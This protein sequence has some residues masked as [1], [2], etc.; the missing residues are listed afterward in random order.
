MVD[1]TLPRRYARSL[2]NHGYGHALYEP[3]SVQELSPGSCGYLNDE[4]A[5]NPI[6]RLDDQGALQAHGL[7]LCDLERAPQS[8]REWGPKTS[9]NVKQ[10]KIDLQGGAS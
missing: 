2:A 5:W 10:R 6:L 9:S 4:G 8:I 3:V 1:K 7:S